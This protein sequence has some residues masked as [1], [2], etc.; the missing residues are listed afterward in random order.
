M[1][2]GQ[3][4]V[5]ITGERQNA[6]LVVEVPTGGRVPDAEYLFPDFEPSFVPAQRLVV[7]S[8]L[9][10]M[11][12]EHFGDPCN[13]NVARTVGLLGDSQ[14]PVEIGMSTLYITA[15][16]HQ[17]RVPPQGIDEIGMIRP[18]S[19]LTDRQRT[20]ESRA[21]FVVFLVSSIEHRQ[22]LV[23]GYINEKWSGPSVRS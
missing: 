14:R 4:T 8:L 23:S 17:Q 1:E 6:S 9:V 18:Q 16:E 13:I 11:K 21:G 20:C 7:F 15:I 3:S 12:A 2:G 10:I 5:G 22:R 19:A